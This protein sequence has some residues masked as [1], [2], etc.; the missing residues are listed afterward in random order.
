MQKGS[1]VI[2][3]LFLLAIVVWAG[4]LF[5]YKN[6]PARVTFASGIVLNVA[7]ADTPE[8]R[9]KGL[10]KREILRDDEGM[11]FVFSTIDRHTMWM[12]DMYFPIDII[13]L[14][15]NFKIVDIHKGVSVASFPNTFQPVTAAGF[16]IETNAGYSNRHAVKV[17]DFVKFE[18]K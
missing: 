3:T 8:L 1:S 9:E 16:A 12:R 18:K 4:W 13:W 5:F 11:I 7:I 10:S 17:G 6:K 2:F 14:D 15:E